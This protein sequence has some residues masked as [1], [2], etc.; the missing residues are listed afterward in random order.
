MTVLADAYSAA[1]SLGDH[2]QDHGWRELYR[3]FAYGLEVE[4][5]ELGDMVI[6]FRKARSES[7]FTHLLT[8]LGIAVK[9]VA[10]KSFDALVSGAIPQPERL[11]A[12]E[13]ALRENGDEIAGILALRQNSFTAARRF[14]SVQIILGAYARAMPGR[15]INFADLGTGLGVL[16]RQLNSRRLFDRF[17]RDLRWC[18]GEPQFL[19][20][21]L[22]RRF[23]VERGPRPDIRW[24]RACYGATDYY[25]DLYH[26]LEISMSAPE[27]AG[28]EVAYGEFDILDHEQLASFI[29]QER[30]NAVN[31][32]YVLY[33]I[34]PERRGRIVDVLREAMLPPKLIIVTEP[35]AELTRPGCTVTLYEESQASP[36]RLCAVSDG[37]FRG[38]VTPLDDYTSFVERCP[39]LFRS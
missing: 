1:R 17:I 8:L 15:W 31:L 24:V 10:E 19:P 39:V 36:Q 35:V 2:P 25:T 14:L 6:T 4:A 7:S 12:L 32:S 9:E 16:P 34:E 5:P 3:L 33:E 20:I 30:I 27:V 37:H 26:E 21:P 28:A 18:D 38:R 29:G 11:E 23:G 22:S 13:A